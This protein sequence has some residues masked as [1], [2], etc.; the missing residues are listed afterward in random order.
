MMLAGAAP[1]VGTRGIEVIQC[2]QDLANSV[3]L[4]ADKAT[5]V[6]IYLDPATVGRSG[7]VGGEIAWSRAA[8]EAYLPAL[9]AVSI[10]PAKPLSIADQRSDLA[11]SLN[12][13]LPPEALGAGKLQLRLNRLFQPGG[14]DL[15]IG[16][17]AP[18]VVELKTAPPLRIRVIGLRYNNGQQD[19]SPAAIQIGRAHV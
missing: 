13:R 17:P 14:P 19:V 11:N 16:N 1:A 3:E 9:N 15:P 12:F 8:A 18:L 10:D 7:K 4:V 6:R 2:I 5:V